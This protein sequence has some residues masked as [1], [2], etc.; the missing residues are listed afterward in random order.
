MGHMK[1]LVLLMAL[2][3]LTMADAAKAVDAKT[4]FAGAYLGETVA[5]FGAYYDSLTETTVMGHSGVP[6]GQTCIDIR[7]M[8]NQEWRVY[9]TFRDSD[10]IIVSV[11]YEKT[12]SDEKFTKKE[13]DFL[14]NLSRGQKGLV[15]K[16][17]N[18]AGGNGPELVVT[19][20]E[21]LKLEDEKHA[22]QTR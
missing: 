11:G 13:I 21:Q 15:T 2:A 22:G 10:G 16:V 9:I 7:P 1:T 17:Y 8:P 19:T 6:D 14:T 3:I 5:K 4:F 18:D 20:T 12:G